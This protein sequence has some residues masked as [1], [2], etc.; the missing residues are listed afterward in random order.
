[1]SDANIIKWESILKKTGESGRERLRDYLA[2]LILGRHINESL[3]DRLERSGLTEF[4]NW[5][6]E[7]TKNNKPI[8]KNFN[9][10]NIA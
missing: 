2:S 4:Y 7:Y 10:N 9:N 5:A 1:M 3:S 8:L 6:L